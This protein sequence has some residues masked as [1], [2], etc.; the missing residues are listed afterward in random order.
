M[1]DPMEVGRQS[2]ASLRGFYCALQCGLELCGVA[3]AGGCWLAVICSNLN[4]YVHA[5]RPVVVLPPAVSMCG[6]R[7]LFYSAGAR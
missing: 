5:L 4:V 7:L 2:S 6:L 1:H 3:K